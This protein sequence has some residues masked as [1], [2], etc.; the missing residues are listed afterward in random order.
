PNVGSLTT[1]TWDFGDGSPSVTIN[2]PSSPNVT[3]TYAA[4]GVYPVTLTVTNS[5]GCVSVNPPVNVT[6]HSRPKA[7]YIVPD[8]CL[9]DTYAQFTDTSTVDA[10]DVLTNWHWDFGD[11]PSGPANTSTLQ[12]PQ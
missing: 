3:H 9:S 10:P 1:W 11:P 7:G 6:I 12:N 8:V 4:A 2:A 5:K